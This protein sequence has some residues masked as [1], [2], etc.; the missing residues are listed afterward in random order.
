M[1]NKKYK[2]IIVGIGLAA[3]SAA[4]RM[5]ELGIKDIGIYMKSYGGTP[6]I[7]AIN[8]VLPDNPYGDTNKQYFDDMINAGYQIGNINLVNEM[9]ENTMNGYNLLKRWD[10]EFAKNEDGTTKLRHLSGHIYPRSLCSTKDLIGVEIGKK[11]INKLKENKVDIYEG[12]ECVKVL[13]DSK[14]I[15]GITV[16]NSEGNLENLYSNIVVAAW[17]GIG[18]LVGVSTYPHDIKGNTLAIAKDAGAKLIDVEFIEY[19]PMVILSPQGALGEPCPTAMLGEGGYLINSKNERFILK[20]RPQGEAGASKTLLN[21]QIW[22]EVNA[23]NGSKNSGVWIDLRHIDR[24]I[25]KS[26][27]WLFKRL[28]DNGI[29]PNRDI[30]EIG[31]MAHSFS[32]GIEVDEN[33]ESS[34][35]GFFAI[36]EACGGIHGA[37]RCAGNAASQAVIS[38]LLCA[39]AIAKKYKD[40]QQT[41]KIFPMEYKSDKNIYEKYMPQIKEIAVKA[42]GIYRKG[43]ILEDAKK[44][45]ENILKNTDIQKDTETLQKIESI[46]YIVKA[47][48]NRKETRGTHIRLDYPEESKDYKK[49]FTI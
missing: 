8:F 36:G 38:G 2:V 49:E 15:Y 10:I 11:L 13:S 23:G 3:L 17:G 21:K 1:E 43:E 20:V 18:N 48:L 42:L 37:C 46:Y 32:G 45:I 5:I 9:A 6:Y 14:K 4:V 29:D 41:I 24:N 12:Y 31:P 40:L 44:H 22:N 7:A 27:P 35:E 30:I 28:M 39:Q 47:A 26:Y 16:K 34:I 33:Y 19:E 25:L